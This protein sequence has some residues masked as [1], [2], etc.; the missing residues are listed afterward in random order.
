MRRV[1]AVALASVALASCASLYSPGGGYAS[2]AQDQRACANL[3]IDPGT[4][5]FT[6]CV[7]NLAQTLR[8]DSSAE[9]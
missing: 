2:Y 7:D 5:E 9:P 3:G 1:I 6:S 4:R 8:D